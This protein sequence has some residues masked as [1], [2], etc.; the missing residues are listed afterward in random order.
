M[1]KH[2]EN[3]IV[4]VSIGDMNGIGPEVILKTFEDTRM[5][6]AC[7]PVIFANA[8]IISFLKKTYQLNAN[9]QGIDK[10]DQIVFGKIN[11]LNIWKE[12]VNLEYG[13][14]DDNVGKYAIK[15]FQAATKALK[16]DKIDVLVTAPI[17]KYNIQ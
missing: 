11:V 13:K 16:E 10:L 3:I 2:S 7:T 15:S 1:V 14:L 9:I 5:L 17:N 4:G 8:K 12:G 6:E